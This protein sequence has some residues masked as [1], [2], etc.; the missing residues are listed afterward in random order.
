[1]KQISNISK[2][3]GMLFLELLLS[4]WSCVSTITILGDN[5]ANYLFLSLWDQDLLQTYFCVFQGNRLGALK[6]AGRVGASQIL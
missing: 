4:F 2:K 3:F 1:M 6:P 5:T